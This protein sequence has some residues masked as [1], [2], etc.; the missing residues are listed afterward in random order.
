MRLHGLSRVELAVG[1]LVS[2]GSVAF[3]SA[4]IEVLR[5]YMPVLTLGVLYVFAVLAVAV[6]WGIELAVVV[7][8]ASMLAFNW[9]FLPPTHTFQLSDGANWAVLA[10]YLVTAVVV[11]ALAAR[12]RRRAELAERRE[13]EATV[14][15][16]M[17]ED[18]LAGTE[19]SDELER[20]G[21]L[22]A[23]VLGVPH[24][25]IEVGVVAAP[26][27][28]AAYPLEAAGGRRVGT[29]F[30]GFEHALDQDAAHR[31]LPALASLL[32]V[33]VDRADL[34]AE[35]LEAEALRRSDT[36]KT[37]LLHAV[38]HDLRSPLTAIVAAASGLGNPDVR[39]DEADR[40]VL[41]ETIRAEAGRLDRLVGNLLDLTRLRSG[42]AAPHPE[43]WPVDGLVA[44]ALEHLGPAEVRVIAELDPDAPPVRVDP[45]Q[46]ERVI[47]NVLENALKFSPEG[48]PVRVHLERAGSE[49][50][51]H[52][53]DEGP[54]VSAEISEAVFE[55]FRRGD[56]TDVRGAGLGL[57]IARGFAEV[58][59]AR[60]WAEIDPSGGH[61]VL[62]LPIGDRAPV[63][64]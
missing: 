21:V 17:A 22:T 19:L 59:D 51:V 48:S 47:V 56:A 58:N 43:L 3:V 50:L 23:S 41:V 11:S 8:V 2:A 6:F 61:F 52:V 12:A 39:L 25:R 49:L 13:R 54:G 62:A 31:F 32:A 16:G 30:I 44:R 26:A 14:L 7:S 5:P 35:A 4:L 27:G 20:V 36:I 42:V 57:A 29:V 46:I 37:A 9:F 40:S 28:E 15:A 55:P 45:V 1:L 33:E 63:P 34:A 24:A 64:A 60:V 53:L 38:S 10:V 18:L